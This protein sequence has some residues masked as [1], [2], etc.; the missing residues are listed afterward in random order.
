MTYAEELRKQIK[1]HNN[2]WNHEQTLGG[3]QKALDDV[4]FIIET[5]NID[6]TKE[7]RDILKEKIEELK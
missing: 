3:Y 7:D 1:I 2:E 4:L 6:I 5:E